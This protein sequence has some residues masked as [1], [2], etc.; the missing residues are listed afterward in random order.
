MEKVK[1]WAHRGASGYVPENTLEAFSKAI[2][3]KADGIELDI[4]M[5]KDGEIVVVHDEKL[6]RV[7]DGSGLVKNHTLAELKRMNFSKSFPGF[8]RTQIPT[9]KEVYEL[10]QGKE[11]TV[12][13]EL[14]TGVFFYEKMVDKALDLAAAMGVED[15]I[16]YSSFNHYTLKEI[17][18]KNPQAVTGMLFMD[19]LVDAPLYGRKLG[20]DALHPVYTHLKYPDF[21]QQCRENNLSLHVWTVNTGQKFREMKAA[22]VDAVITNYPDVQNL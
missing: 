8:G 12:N 3:M 1:I 7:S 15:R 5:S 16:L 22:G 4:Q 2:E 19:G 17:K 9:L 11:I 13:V 21:L 6:G 20:V 10:V 18:E 14:K